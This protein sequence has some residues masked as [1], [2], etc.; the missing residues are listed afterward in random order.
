[1]TIVWRNPSRL[2]FYVCFFIPFFSHAPCGFLF[3]LVMISLPCTEPMDTGDPLPPIPPYSGGGVL[4]HPGQRNR[5]RKRVT[6]APVETM[7]DVYYFEIE[8]GERGMRIVRGYP[9]SHC[10]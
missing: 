8:E 10:Q 9:A 7:R 1:M 6:W 3:L 4:V 5:V 2:L